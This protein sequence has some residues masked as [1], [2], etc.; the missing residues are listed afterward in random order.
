MT[1]GAKDIIVNYNRERDLAA[2]SDDELIEHLDT[3]L[4]GGTMSEH[5]KSVLTDYLA[6]FN[7]DDPER[8][9]IEAVSMVITSPEFAVQR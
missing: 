6:S 4:L 8:K 3:L 9:A 7:E 5:M 1:K 2:S